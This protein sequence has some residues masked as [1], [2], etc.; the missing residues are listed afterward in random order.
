MKPLYLRLQAFGP[1]AESIDISFDR[2]FAGGLFLIHGRTGAGKTSLLDGICF[3]LFGRPSG[4]ERE[5][6]LRAL[7]SDLAAANCLT[8]TE[9]VFALGDKAFRVHRTPT[10]NRPKKNADGFTEHKGGAELYEWPGPLADLRQQLVEDAAAALTPARWLPLAGKLEAVDAAIEERLGMNEKQFRQVAILPQGRFRE[11]L[12]ST[13]AERQ[14]IL[15]KLFQTDRFSR[16]QQWLTAQAK[17][18]ETEWQR[19]SRDLSIKLES[20]ELGSADEIEGRLT[21]ERDVLVA[22][23]AQLAELE[24][25]SGPLR[26]ELETARERTQVQTE[27]HR[28]MQ[29]QVELEAEA[30]R[31]TAQRQRLDESRRLA[32]AYQLAET[33]TEQTLKLTDLRGTVA[34][35]KIQRQAAEQRFVTAQTRLAEQEQMTPSL[36]DL[37]EERSQLREQL[38]RLSEL[39]KLEAQATADAL[40]L[41]QETERRA[42]LTAERTALDIEKQLCLKDL[43]WADSALTTEAEQQLAAADKALAENEAKAVQL[44]AAALAA[45]LQPEQPC[46]VCGSTEHP[47]PAA[48]AATQTADALASAEA[49][50]KRAQA[51]ILAAK[52]RLEAE[53]ISRRTVLEPLRPQ[54]EPIAELSGRNEA[55]SKPP[56]WSQLQSRLESLTGKTQN[57]AQ[58]AATLDGAIAAK[59]AQLQT[60]QHELTERTTSLSLQT[61]TAR[62]AA[63]AITRRGLEIKALSER[64]ELDL[65]AA[66]AELQASGTLVATLTARCESLSTQIDELSQEA[67]RVEARWLDEL[68]RA[69]F[70]VEAWE[71]L[72]RERAST[73]DQRVWEEEL[74]RFDSDRTQVQSALTA[75]QLKRQSLP[76]GRDAA[77]IEADLGECRSQQTTLLEN[78]GR[79]LGRIQPLEKLQ[80]EA[81]QSQGELAALEAEAKQAARMALRLSGDRAA[82]ALAVPLARFVLQSRFEDVLEQANVRLARMSRGQYRLLRPALSRNLAQSQGLSIAVEDA[83]SGKERPADSLSGGESFMASLSLALGLADVVQADLGSIRLDS[84]LVD[85]G[86]GTLDAEALD[87]ALRTLVDLQAGGRMV[88]IISHVAE[89]KSQIH[90]RLEILKTSDGSQPV[91]N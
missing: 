73:S 56:A 75:L 46:P 1:F 76:D 36:R 71:R 30:P 17:G 8:E 68:G 28:L 88:G 57:L 14:V 55:S 23:E 70:Q 29:R 38:I 51:Q 26:S 82:N 41:R 85:E 50:I 52:A 89:L 24:K 54:L 65:K 72:K 9:L 74:S 61:T 45:T 64:R 79:A 44:R 63:D 11:F 18:L 25:Q 80:R 47:A 16:F 34:A 78:K 84:V 20:L 19:L 66:T 58:S 53:R 4:A 83:V 33:L 27:I 13:S 86:F 5:R 37:G 10:Q 77:A 15:E 90:D 39:A 59:Q 3:S 48:P 81:K 22:I 2:V 31:L 60:R 67:G 49:D 91:W 35:L 62:E 43:F 40:T 6:D 12:S 42:A 69:G 7:R 21:I 87:F 32:A